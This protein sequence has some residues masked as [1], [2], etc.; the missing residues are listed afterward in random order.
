MSLR[1]ETPMHPKDAFAAS[2]SEQYLRR[3]LKGEGVL[4]GEGNVSPLDGLEQRFPD[5]D[6]GILNLPP[7]RLETL[8]NNQFKGG[9]HVPGSALVA[10]KY[11]NSV[12]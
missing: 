12:F 7:V 5:T 10:K 6:T 11:L 1:Y 9:Y 3:R 2:V 8:L 4:A